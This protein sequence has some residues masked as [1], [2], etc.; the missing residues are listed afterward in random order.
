MN[1]EVILPFENRLRDAVRRERAS[2]DLGTARCPECGWPLRL[3][4]D[5]LGPR[6]ECAC[7]FR[8]RAA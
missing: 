1:D 8:E 4:L 6:F 3:R 2:E 5:C 7:P